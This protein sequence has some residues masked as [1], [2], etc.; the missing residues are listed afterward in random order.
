MNTVTAQLCAP[1]PGRLCEG[2]VWDSRTQE[3]LWVDIRGGQIHRAT[4]ADP[5]PDLN[6]RATLTLTPPVSAV[7][8]CASG[9]LL[10]TVGDT[11]FRID[12]SNEDIS[13]VATVPMPGDGEGRRL[14]DAKVD[15]RGRLL[16]GT[17][18]EAG[19]VGSAALYRVDPDGSLARLRTGITI[20]NGLGWSP[21]GRT[22]YYADSPTHRVDVFDYDL[23]TGTLGEGKPFAHFP[24]GDPDGLTVDAEGNVWVAVWGAGQVR[25]FDPAGNP[26]TTVEVG[27]SQVSSC[28]F[29]GPD[30]D[31]LVI[32]TA[33][34]REAAGEPHAGRLFACRPGVTGLPSTP[35]AD[36]RRD[37]AD[38]R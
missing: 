35:F 17:M 15:P 21:D 26:H 32:T 22:L 16:A 34:E 38:G 30:L 9:R 13:P 25:A 27:P 20:S 10:A 36:E 24:D 29:A 12:G 37:A 28:T 8:P 11:I 18:V 6:P 19:G 1:P 7:L 2:P 4:L 5:T 3:L 33:A 14:N 23:D 31:V